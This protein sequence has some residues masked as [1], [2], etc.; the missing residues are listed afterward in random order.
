MHPHAAFLQP[1]VAPRMP[2]MHYP[3]SFMQTSCRPQEQRHRLH[4]GPYEPHLLLCLLCAA[5]SQ[6][7]DWVEEEYGQ[8]MAPLVPNPQY[9]GEWKAPLIDNPRYKVCQFLI[10]HM[11]AAYAA[12]VNAVVV[13]FTMQPMISCETA[14]SCAC[15]LL[16]LFIFS[17]ISLYFLFVF[18][19]KKNPLVL[20]CLLMVRGH[21]AR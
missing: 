11:H 3:Y 7:T 9:K 19:D 14:S 6:P 15:T 20:L 12:H 2:P 17:F 21:P 16:F 5:K 13:A 18:S 1:H 8:W 4:A 10:S